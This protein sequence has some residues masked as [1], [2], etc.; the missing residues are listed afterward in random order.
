MPA[1]F[2][3]CSI[4]TAAPWCCILTLQQCRIKCSCKPLQS[5]SAP[6][7]FTQLCH[8]SCSRQRVNS[9]GLSCLCKISHPFLTE[10][11]RTDHQSQVKSLNHEWSSFCQT[12]N[13][14]HASLYSPRTGMG[15]HYSDGFSLNWDFKRSQTPSFLSLFQFPPVAAQSGQCAPNS[16]YSDQTRFLFTVCNV[17]RDRLTPWHMPAGDNQLWGEMC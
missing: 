5:V 16:L 10:L 9:I 12:L 6:Q 8:C 11:T 2:T 15:F 7:V 1:V 14:P 13:T 4:V 17:G 3:L